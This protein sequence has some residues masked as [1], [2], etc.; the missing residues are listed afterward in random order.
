MYVQKQMEIP[1]HHSFRGVG[2]WRA[3]RILRQYKN[4]RP[5]LK[6]SGVRVFLAQAVLIGARQN[7]ELAKEKF[8]ATDRASFPGLWLLKNTD[9][10]STFSDG[11]KSNIPS[12]QIPDTFL[13]IR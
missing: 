2:S 13:W 5:L 1:H 6:G 7:C 8:F 12:N 9:I 11:R 3:D 10:V 4:K